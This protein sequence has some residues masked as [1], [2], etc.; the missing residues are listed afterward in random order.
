LENV[1]KFLGQIEAINRILLSINIFFLL[2]VFNECKYT[3]NKLTDSLKIHSII[4][5]LDLQSL[6]NSFFISVVIVI[7][8]KSKFRTSC[9]KKM[10]Y[11]PFRSQYQTTAVQLTG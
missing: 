1:G 11:L 5:S 6:M 4:S 10:F 7:S 3:L 9:T 2:S 8:I